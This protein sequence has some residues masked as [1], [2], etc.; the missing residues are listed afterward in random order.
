M[1]IWSA[2]NGTAGSSRLIRTKLETARDDDGQSCPV[3]LSVTARPLLQ[4][5]PKPPYIA[6]AVQDFTLGPLMDALDLIEHRGESVQDV[7]EQL[8]SSQGTFGH[9]RRPGAHPGLLEWTANALSRF[10]AARAEDQETRIAGGHAPTSPVEHAWVVLRRLNRPDR[11]GAS[12]Y[13]AT[14]WGRRYAA[15]DGSAR[16]LWL[17]SFGQAKS[18]RPASVKAAAAHVAA[19]GQPCTGGRGPY[20]F[21]ALELPPD[22]PSRTLPSRVRVLDFGCGDGNLVPLVDWDRQQVDQHFAVDAKP[23]LARAVDGG[24]PRPGSSCVDCKALGGCRALPQT[25]GLLTVAASS[26]PQARRSVSVSDLRAYA[27][28][29]A[30]Y[31]LVRQL[32]LKTP[33]PENEAIRRGRAVDAWLNDRHRPPVSGNCRS[34]PSA[35]DTAAWIRTTFSLS[36]EGAGTGARMLLEHK[37]Y[38]SLDG[39]GQEEQVL[40]QHQVTCY[41]RESNLVWIATPDL[42]HTRSGGWTWRETK[43]ST[44][45]LFEGEPLL[46]RYPQLALA[47][48]MLNAGVLGGDLARSRVELEVLYPD[49]ATLEEVDPSRPS[50]VR[51][52][53]DVLTSMAEPWLQDRTFQPSP[54]RNCEGCEA[55]DWCEPGRTHQAAGHSEDQ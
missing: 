6:A 25:P 17:L 16:D 54:G 9:T 13:E 32:K 7:V 15:S 14:G 47:V 8:W 43:T 24:R 3:A 38:C 28:C 26:E 52:A 30:Q 49:D 40:V 31:H 37:A 33:R 53:R 4:A 55:L 20:P 34:T 1:Q 36:E 48:L 21:R 2:P 10:L 19:Y 45:L 29:P 35:V 44:S 42:L 41:D 46:R 11:R 50:V 27:A 12:T 23:A 18:D 22:H 5:H 39:L 51:E